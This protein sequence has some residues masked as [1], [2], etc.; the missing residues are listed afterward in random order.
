M[1]KLLFIILSFI[2][3]C[4]IGQSRINGVYVSEVNLFKQDTLKYWIGS[5]KN[6]LA[7]FSKDGYYGLIDTTGKVRIPL[8]YDEILFFEDYILY[9]S[10]KMQKCTNYNLQIVDLKQYGYEA[11]IRSIDNEKIYVPALNRY[12]FRYTFRNGLLR[13]WK[14]VTEGPYAFID[15]QGNVV[16]DFLKYNRVGDFWNGFAAVEYG[17]LWGTINTKGEEVIKPAYDYL[18]SYFQD[19]LIK[20]IIDGKVGF[21]DTLGK[22]IIP[23]EFESAEYPNDGLIAVKK[24]GKHG[25]LNY[26]GNVAINFIY[27]YAQPFVNGLAKVKMNNKEGYINRQGEFIVG[28]EDTLS[29]I[30]YHGKLTSVRRGRYWAFADYKGNII[31]TLLSDKPFSFDDDGYAEFKKWPNYGVVNKLGEII[32]FPGQTYWYNRGL[33]RFTRLNKWGFIDRA[34]NIIVQPIYDLVFDFSGDIACVKLN[35]KWGAINKKGEIVIP[36]KY[37][38][39]HLHFS[40]YPFAVVSD[41]LKYGVIDRGGKTVVPFKYESILP[42]FEHKYDKVLFIVSESE[43]RGAYNSSGELIIPVKFN[44]IKTV[45]NLYIIASTDEQTTIFNFSGK[46]IKSVDGNFK[47]ALSEIVIVEKNGAQGFYHY[48]SNSYCTPKFEDIRFYNDTGTVVI[49]GI[50]RF[51][52]YKGEYIIKNSYR[53]AR[54]FLHGVAIVGVYGGMKCINGKGEEL[55]KLYDEINNFADGLALVKLNN[56]YGYIDMTGN[57]VI[58]LQYAEAKQ[59]GDGLAPV[60]ING[61]WGYIDK[62]NQLVIPAE[63]DTAS[64]FGRG[65]ARVSKGSQQF[66]INTKNRIVNR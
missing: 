54:D 6:G 13:I 25:Y 43:K 32:S 14:D 65:Y 52:N 35:N 61:K 45:E 55:S 53:F 19:G 22:I 41:S 59:F 10:D 46:L 3:L 63:Y 7:K 33:E 9:K 12:F 11:I 42:V 56:K 62:S 49:N 37:A 51:I 8:E 40:D 2:S 60:K 48:Q 24:N 57:E 23:I 4:V 28:P 17:G 5:F 20:V 34:G 21:I 38:T 66:T 27:D 44:K 50:S 1:K 26:N 18:S 39:E 16:I 29:K 47:S 58:P 31:D 30:Y 64:P 15:R 36:I